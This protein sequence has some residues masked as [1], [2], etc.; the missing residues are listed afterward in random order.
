MGDTRQLAFT[1]DQNLP[2]MSS[3]GV[4][5]SHAQGTPVKL[6]I[7]SYQAIDYGPWILPRENERIPGCVV[8]GEGVHGVLVRL[9]RVF[10]TFT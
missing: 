1:Y 2:E 10:S 5:V 4:G 3:H 8:V 9:P 6:K 7:H